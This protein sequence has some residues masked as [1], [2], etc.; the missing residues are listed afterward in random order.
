[1][2]Q[3][4]K[5]Q[6]RYK[7]IDVPKGELLSWLNRLLKT[8]YTTVKQC[9]NGAA[10]CQVLYSLFPVSLIFLD[11]PKSLVFCLKMRLVG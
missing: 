10:Y 8:D 1:M 2:Q 5:G 9:S 3:G 4:L 6:L 11:D 7:T